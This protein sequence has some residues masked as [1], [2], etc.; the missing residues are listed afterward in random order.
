VLYFIYLIQGLFINNE[1]FFAPLSKLG[2]KLIFCYLL[3]YLQGCTDTNQSLLEAL[4]NNDDLTAKHLLTENA[5]DM[6]FRDKFGYTPLHL[7]NDAGI[8]LLL[9][10]QG[11]DVNAKG[12]GLDPN[13]KP[14]KNVDLGKFGTFDLNE[15]KTGKDYSPLH[16]VK[17]VEVATLLIKHG[18][19]VNALANYNITPLHKAADR[20]IAWHWLACY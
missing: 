7:A 19:N 8:A 11:A 6:Q 15:L 10:N 12:A 13:I 5:L 1:A 4:R 17:S 20:K 9:I 18:A 3:L 14:I 2:F 16:T